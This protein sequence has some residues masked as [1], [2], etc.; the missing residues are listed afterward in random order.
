M[1]R[2]AVAVSLAFALAA[3]GCRERQSLTS[4]HGLSAAFSDGSVTG[5][6]PHFFFLPPLV[7]QPNFSGTF[8]PNL[9]PVVEICQLDVD[10]VTNTP[11]GCNATAP[12][13]NPGLVQLDAVNQ[14]YHVDW[15]T[16]AP[17]IDLTKFY[18]IQVFSSIEAFRSPGTKPLGLADIAPVAN[19]SQLKD[20]NTGQIIGLVDGR[21]LPI[22]FRIEQGVTCVGQTDCVEQTLGPSTTEQHVVTPD[23]FAAASFPPGYFAQT[24]T[25]TIHRVPEPCLNTP[26]QQFD[27]CYSFATSPLAGDVL[28]CLANPTSAS[29]C[30]RVE[31]CLIVPST[32]PLH[33]HL[34]LFRSDPG[35]PA[36]E[37]P[38]VPASLINCSTFLGGLGPH[39]IVDLA[40]ATWHRMGSALGRLLAPEPLFARSAM[41]HLGLGGL[42][43]CFSN[44]GWAL[45]ATMTPRTPTNT[46]APTGTP[47]PVSVLVRA[48]HPLSEVPPPLSGVQVTFAATPGNGAVNPMS[49]TIG[50]DGIASTQWTLGAGSNSVRASAAASGSP[51]TFTAI[52]TLLMRPSS[53][54][55]TAQPGVTL[56]LTQQSG[57]S[58]QGSVVAG[59]MGT[60]IQLEV[61]P[62]TAVTWSS[63]DPFGT[64]AS[65]N[66]TGLLVVSQGNVDPTT[67][68]EATI[69]AAVGTTAVASIKVNSFSFDHFPRLTTLVWRPVPGAVSYDVS[70][71]FGNGPNNTTCSTPAT[72]T[73][74][75]PQLTANTTNLQF[76]FQFVGAQPGRWRVVANDATGAPISISELVYFGYII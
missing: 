24:V 34:A 31:V 69:S 23:G 41:G 47:V 56:P 42:S 43:C 52:G 64:T 3:V 68:H 1:K 19:G 53:L 37:L 66:T 58:M 46:T 45:P 44:I 12:L 25:L 73:V 30:A 7:G 71:E 21:T 36:T 32:N 67:A 75:L 2:T 54:A 74:W 59:G 48:L 49:V 9:A 8:N 15:H 29:A 10:P 61:S 20:V 40:R 76:V 38:D 65:I 39:G 55:L 50:L 72:C 35:L 22:K 4:P 6:N 14:Q 33:D 13:I 51:K 11:L 5:G 17:A 70:V 18:R 57:L 28:G 60:G 26:F 63:S 27:G 16:D 62:A